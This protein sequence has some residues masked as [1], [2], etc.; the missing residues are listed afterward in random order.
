MAVARGVGKRHRQASWHTVHQ[1]SRHDIGPND[2]FRQLSLQLVARQVRVKFL[3]HQ[4]SQQL[5][6]RWVHGVVLSRVII[7]AVFLGHVSGLHQRQVFRDGQ[8][9]LFR[10]LAEVGED[11]G[12]RARQHGLVV[13]ASAKMKCYFYKSRYRFSF[14]F[15]LIKEYRFFDPSP[16][17]NVSK[18]VDS[19]LG[20][21]RVGEGGHKGERREDRCELHDGTRPICEA[22][23]RMPARTKTTRFYSRWKPRTA[24]EF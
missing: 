17:I 9:V 1:G 5:L 14:L 3:Q 19:G 16:V 23:H 7:L 22:K 4:G 6:P 21:L 11:F 10:C 24:D 15:F 13:Y 2:G 8:P 20:P 18:G 12:L